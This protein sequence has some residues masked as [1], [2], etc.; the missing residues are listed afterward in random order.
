M[1]LIS[2]LIFLVSI[3]QPI[4]AQSKK[5]GKDSK[6]DEKPW[7]VTNPVGPHKDV[8]FDLDE[9]TWMNLDVSPDGST[10]IFDL[11]G[12]IY[13]MP[14]SG[15]NAKL[16][17]G[18]HA[19]E[20][21]PRYSPNGKQISF[22]SDAGGADNIWVMNAD[23]SDA[24]QITKED[25][26]LLNNAVW[27]VDGNY[28]IAR[29]HFTNTRSAGAGELWMYH[30]SGGSGIQLTKKKNDQQD[31]GE[32]FVSSDG[33]YVYY[34]EDVYPGGFFQYNKDAN[35][36]IYVIK[37]LDILKGGTE[38]SVRGPGGAFRPT[39]SRDG[40]QLAFVRRVRERSVLFIRDLATGIENPIYSEL[41]KDQQEAWA[42]FGVYTNFNWTPDNKSIIIWAKGKIRSINVSSG[43][44]AIIPFKL[45]SSHKFSDALHF[46][47]QA[48][49]D[50][51][52]V[53]T[54]RNAVT[55][56]DGK[57]LVFNA[58]GYLWTKDLPNGKPHRI[59]NSSDFEFDPSFSIDGKQLTYVTW[60]DTALGK[61]MLMNW[62]SGMISAKSISKE[63]GIFR[64]PKISP[65]NS[66][67]VYVKEEGNDHQGFTYCTNPGIYISDI[68]TG[69]AERI[70]KDGD[71]PQFSA[72]GKRIFFMTG[73]YLFG[74]LAKSFKS[75]DFS[76]N[77]EITHYTSKYANQFVPS[78]DNKW[79][80]FNELFKVYLT[81]LIQVGAS[82]DLTH[83][84][85]AYPVKQVAKDAG[86]NL[87]WSGNGK[88]LH[89]TLGEEYTTVELSDAFDLNSS[90]PIEKFEAKSVGSPIGLRLASDKPSGLIAYK[91]AR[92]ISMKGDEVIEDGTILVKDNRIQEIGSST[93]VNIPEGTKIID[94]KGKTI[95]PGIVDVHAHLGTFRYGLSPQQQWSYFANL[96]FGVTTTH[97]PSS[98]TEMVFSQSEMVKAGNMVGP[99]IYSTG[100]ILY[101]ADGDFKAEINSLEDAKSALRRTKAFGAFSV[102]SY[103]QPRRNQRQQVIAAARELQME[104]VPEGGSHFFHN[105]TMILDGHTG[106][107]HN[108]PVHDIYQDVIKFWSS[109]KTG[110]TPTLIVSYGAM[111][112]EF[113]YYDKDNVWEDKRLMNFTPRAIVDARSRHREKVPDEE[114]NAGHI[115]V[116]Q[117]CKQLA[118]AGV[119]V[120]L[121]AHGQ[122]QGLGAHWELK[123]LAAG[124]MSPLQAIRCATVNGAYYIGME[125][126]IG[127]L[128]KGKL[129]DFIILDKNPLDDINHIGSIAMTVANGRLYD[130]MSMN[131]LGFNAKSRMPFYFEQEH[132]NDDFIWHEETHGFHGHSCG[133]RK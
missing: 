124:G 123:M 5:N 119:K 31:L 56:P 120:N 84:S 67:I 66:Q 20:V 94:C 61:I 13:S 99:R 40:K 49:P 108:I 118:D 101:G 7:D 62:P 64:S 100:I 133:C 25:F 79:L 41:S 80:M 93:Q 83:G 106:I 37:R 73:G 9:G 131:E 69:K 97:D 42:I 28:L 77:D 32:P 55:S 81:P 17:R 111:N 63:K 36:Q 58:V 114:Y 122:I 43:E 121:G 88:Q 116:S 34:S 105:M 87:H 95:M 10:I 46:K 53:K 102:K 92:I 21:Q 44:S 89:W 91:N 59:T 72:N 19:Y 82:I 78:P 24:K 54:I 52:N 6:K 98:N 8:S 65:D 18:G 50:S 1:R 16:L 35:K 15:G 74:D 12:D 51:F 132:G 2:T 107:E 90:I 115:R 109:S 96:A 27:T 110:Y 71:F 4:L 29:K 112:G 57:H 45:T 70:M 130:S 3:C 60:N 85:S 127:S 75:A 26:R 11:L 117:S 48:A 76:G 113:Y 30:I 125:D 38:V 47:Q 39:L 129:A 14:I 128:E 86:I 68:K 22:T 33:R 103:N 104:V 126:E 23:G